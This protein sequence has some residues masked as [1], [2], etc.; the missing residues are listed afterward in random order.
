ML[1]N[2]VLVSAVQQSQSGIHKHISPLFWTCLPFRSPQSMQC[3]RFSLV[4]YF[5][6]SKGHGNPL[7]YSC[8]EN[9][10]GQRSLAGYCPWG[11]KES[12][13]TEG[14][15]TAHME[16]PGS[17]RVNHCVKSVVSKAGQSRCEPELHPSCVTLCKPLTLSV[18]TSSTGT[19]E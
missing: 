4:I 15:S 1:Y 12:D 5:I 2:V 19:S 13:M 8:L 6:R 16:Q 9:P 17:F 7:Q 11:H 10:H 14:L 18:P 3:S